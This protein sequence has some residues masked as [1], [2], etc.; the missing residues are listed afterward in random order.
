MSAHAQR[1][2][3]PDSLSQ[4]VSPEWL[5]PDLCVRSDLVAEPAWLEFSD[6]TGLTPASVWSA[7]Y[8]ED[9]TLQGNPVAPKELEPFAEGRVDVSTAT[10]ASRRVRILDESQVLPGEASFATVRMNEQIEQAAD[11]PREQSESIVEESVLIDTRPK[12]RLLDESQVLSGEASFA[13]VMPDEPLRINTYSPLKEFLVKTNLSSIQLVLATLLLVSVIAV[14]TF[15]FL[16]ITGGEGVLNSPPTVNKAAQTSP[17]E[18]EPATAETEAVT[19]SDSLEPVAVSKP[20][21]QVRAAAGSTPEENTKL[22]RASETAGR[23]FPE[24]AARQFPS[25]QLESRM[26]VK[27]S[28]QNA[29]SISAGAAPASDSNRQATSAPKRLRAS[30]KETV[31]VRRAATSKRSEVNNSRSEMVVGKRES[32]SPSTDAAEKPKDEPKVPPV[33]GGGQRPRKV[34]P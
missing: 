3:E 16:M 20:K 17:V 32:S 18:A 25:K 14:G 4:R 15:L 24:E 34:T 5:Q 10:N 12:A 13:T 29:K 9:I 30:M 33:T 1:S 2:D 31:I 19:T 26:S 22:N 28:T 7:D 23:T 27:T 21:E 11:K 8:E 6:S